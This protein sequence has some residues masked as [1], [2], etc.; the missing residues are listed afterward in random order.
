MSGIDDTVY[1][2]VAEL[3]RQLASGDNS[4]SLFDSLDDGEES[5]EPKSEVCR[6]KKRGPKPSIKPKPHEATTMLAY[7]KFFGH[8]IHFRR[9]NSYLTG[10]KRFLPNADV[11]ADMMAQEIIPYCRKRQSKGPKMYSK[12][13]ISFHACRLYGH[14]TE[15]SPSE[16]K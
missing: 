8:Y 11:S 2:G 4:D 1:K 9:V 15:T 3:E 6:P 13:M 7:Q 14:T 16:E 10:L 12:F 5:E